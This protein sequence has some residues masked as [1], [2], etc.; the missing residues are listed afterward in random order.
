VLVAAW[1]NYFS[2]S[3]MAV[4][5][6]SAC[7]ASQAADARRNSALSAIAAVQ[8]EILIDRTDFDA[9]EPR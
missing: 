9:P 8:S 6:M 5:R 3:I 1:G 7:N 2:T 4:R